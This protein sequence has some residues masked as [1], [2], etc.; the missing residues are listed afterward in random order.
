MKPGDLLWV[1]G[2]AE[3]CRALD[4]MADANRKGFPQRR[5]LDIYHTDRRKALDFGIRRA[6]AYLLRPR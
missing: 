4:S 6:Q 5:W 3:P 1:P 2:H